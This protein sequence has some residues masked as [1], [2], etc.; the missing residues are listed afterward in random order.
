MEDFLNECMTDLRT[1]DQTAFT[2][3]FCDHCRQPGCHRA[4]WAGDKFGARVAN[5]ADLLLR[6]VLADHTSSRYEGLVDFTDLL[7]Q[8]VQL[9]MSAQSGD[10][11][12]PT[13]PKFM[14]KSIVF[15]DYLEDGTVK[16]AVEW[17]AAQ[18]KSQNPSPDLAE[19]APEPSPK[20][21]LPEGIPATTVAPVKA[22]SV[23]SKPGNV[24][25]PVG[26]IMIGGPAPEASPKPVVV[27]PWALPTTTTDRVVENGAKI[28]MGG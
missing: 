25:V 13:V 3:T 12:I 21:V 23:P 18:I 28:K 16:R 26:G 10:W 11:T 6:P 15:P 9:Q 22:S 1:K 8:A 2:A 4:K 24:P 20:P 14:G 19:T 27:D 17:A 5:Q 7:G